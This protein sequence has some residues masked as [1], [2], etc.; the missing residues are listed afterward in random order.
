MIVRGAS[1]ELGSAR[2]CSRSRAVDAS[3]RKAQTVARPCDRREDGRGDTDRGD[4]DHAVREARSA[5]RCGR[6]GRRVDRGPPR[7]PDAGRR[8]VHRGRSR[9]RRGHRSRFSREAAAAAAV[10]SPHVVQMLDHGVVD[11]SPFIVMELLEGEDLRRRI[12]RDRA[13]AAARS[14]TPSSRRP[15]RRSARRTARA[16]STATSSR[17]TSSS[18]ERRRRGLREA[19]RLR[20]RQE[21]RLGAAPLGATQDRHAR[22]HAVLHEPGAGARARRASTF[23]RTSGRSASSCSRR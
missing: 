20:H 11:G 2:R 18:A 7:A 21:G 13:P 3:S 15:A 14:S 22:G 19:P 17:T 9:D 1:S 10:K 12:D 5:A 8:Q 4:A 16:S 6:D 23:A